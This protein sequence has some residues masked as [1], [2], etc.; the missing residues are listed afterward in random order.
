MHGW[1]HLSPARIS[2]QRRR[3]ESSRCR[4]VDFSAIRL[5]R[6]VSRLCRSLTGVEICPGADVGERLCIDRGM[7][8]VIGETSVVDD[9]APGT[10]VV[11]NPA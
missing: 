10:T 8:T 7:V 1:C 3:S 5:Y 2:S 9:V 6:P 4:R 11:G